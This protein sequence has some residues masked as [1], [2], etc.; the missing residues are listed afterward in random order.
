MKSPL[1]NHSLVAGKRVCS[2]SAVR[3]FSSYSS[4]SETSDFCWASSGAQDTPFSAWNTANNVSRLGPKNLFFDNTSSWVA[5]SSS[6]S[7]LAQ[8]RW[9]RTWPLSISSSSRIVLSRSSYSIV[10]LVD[11]L[12]ATMF[13]LEGPLS[14]EHPSTVYC[15]VC[16]VQYC[17]CCLSWR[18]RETSLERSNEGSC[19]VFERVF[20]EVQEHEPGPVREWGS[21]NLFLCSSVF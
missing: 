13:S 18:W 4:L 19:R 21:I 17:R 16:T 15:T 7:S 9:L 14:W 3:L 10:Q 5:A 1:W 12:L 20:H 2:S 11:L 8:M 6:S